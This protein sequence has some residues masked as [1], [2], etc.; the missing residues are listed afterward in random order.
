MDGGKWATTTIGLVRFGAYKIWFGPIWFWLKNIGSKM[1]ESSGGTFGHSPK[2]PTVTRVACAGEEGETARLQPPPPP[3]VRRLRCSLAPRPSPVS[4]FCA[5]EILVSARPSTTRL[6]SLENDSGISPARSR[7]PPARSDSS[8]RR[9]KVLP[10]W[11][12]TLTVKRSQSKFR[13]GVVQ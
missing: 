10:T 8:S 2:S 12:A 3:H 1:V 7:L 13:P 6:D 4:C 9:V 5:P 11:H